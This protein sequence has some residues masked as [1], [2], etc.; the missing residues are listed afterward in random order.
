[1]AQNQR[2]QRPAPSN[3]PGLQDSAPAPTITFEYDVPN[4]D[5]LWNESTP[6]FGVIRSIGL[7]L[8]TP[9][10][11]K[12]AAAAAKGDVMQLAYELTRRSICEVTNDRG[13]TVKVYDHDG[14][15]NALWAQMHPKIRGLATVAY[16]TEAAPSERASVL[17]QKS[18]RVKA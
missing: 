3:I 9:L 11:E 15:S 2:P 7:R 16:S 8:L 4:E 18:R 6:D 1:M 14:T 17:F 12:D 5:G 13:E 10:Q